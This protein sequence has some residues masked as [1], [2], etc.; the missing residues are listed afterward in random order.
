ME[1]RKKYTGLIILLLLPLISV[2]GQ[3]DS[4][5]WR[6]GLGAA[7]WHY[8]GGLE[9]GSTVGENGIVSLNPD[10]LSYTASIE[11]LI[12]ESLGLRST[13]ASTPGRRSISDV[14][15]LVSWYTDNRYMFGRRAFM[16][17]YL[18]AGIGRDHERGDIHIPFGAGMK[19]R[20]GGRVNLNIEYLPRTYPE[21]WG[22]SDFSFFDDLRTMTS[23]SLH[24]NLARRKIPY[25]AAKLYTSNRYSYYQK[26]ILPLSIEI[27][28][29]DSTAIFWQNEL[30]ITI[31]LEN[32]LIQN[33]D[34][35]LPAD[36]T[37]TNPGDSIA[38]SD[39][40]PVADHPADMNH[41]PE[42]ASRSEATQMQSTTGSTASDN[43]YS[44]GDLAF[45]S[46]VP[47]E[48]KSFS[49]S[50]VFVRGSNQNGNYAP[51]VNGLNVDALT[52]LPL[53][54]TASIDS[55]LQR[56]KLE[57]ETLK[58]KEAFLREKNDFYRQK[59]SFLERQAAFSASTSDAVVSMAKESPGTISNTK[60][61]TESNSSKKGVDPV[62]AGIG[63]AGVAAG[64][65]ALG[66]SKQNREIEEL[67]RQVLQLQT[68]LEQLQ[69]KF[70][71]NDSL[72][73]YSET[74]SV[75]AMDS[76]GGAAGSNTLLDTIPDEADPVIEKEEIF[77]SQSAE[78][79]S[80]DIIENT[81]TLEKEL[82]SARFETLNNSIVFFRVNSAVVNDEAISKLQEIADFCRRQ[83]NVF[84]V[85]KGYTDQTGDPD[86]NLILAEKRCL[87]V[88]DYF[89]RA[90]VEELR[91]TAVN[92][93][94]DRELSK[95]NDAYGRRV[96][97]RLE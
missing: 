29:Q 30:S 5:Q 60:P 41:I 86:Y 51:H 74:D 76:K 63:A 96:V 33:G 14:S 37:T 61:A 80:P 59:I 89:L 56:M 13:M 23:A 65:S 3:Q 16:A 24:Y 9:S 21:E 15:L 48:G 81:E 77:H 46:A 57:N 67:S 54:N 83:E 72:D 49:D 93:G 50:T 28:P 12:S 91:I 85:I 40:A 58:E 20:I 95:P 27:L 44:D 22:E 82:F 69:A 36:Q 31:P 47:V 90:G 8:H 70:M 18:N 38:K 4:F 43:I 7:N 10:F 19:F 35:N 88:R 6:I 78:P 34:T 87:A 64:V 17:P 71:V 32:T 11:F 55:Q 62:V 79:I 25:R 26:I 53:E 97:I 42:D 66:N 68:T 92:S 52:D 45:F 94:I 39:K 2:M 75:M 73:I 84:L 1:M